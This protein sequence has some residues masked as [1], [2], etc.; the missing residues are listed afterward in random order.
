MKKV[1]L[2]LVAAMGLLMSSCGIHQDA[3]SNYNQL[4]TQ[5]VLNQANFEVVGTAKGECT[6][7]YIFGIGGM[8]KKSMSES[9]TSEMHKN[10]NLRGSQ[11]IINS[12]VNFKYTTILGVYTTVTATANGTIIEFKK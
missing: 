10:A 5:V 12:N 11:A 9:A 3:T 8:S 7:V 1:L 4:Q 6:Q 2:M